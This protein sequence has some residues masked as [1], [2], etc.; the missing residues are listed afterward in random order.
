MR[1]SQARRCRGEKISL[2]VLNGARLRVHVHRSAG[3]GRPIG[4][5]ADEARPKM[6]PKSAAE[7]VLLRL[8]AGQDCFCGI[9]VFADA[10]AHNVRICREP[11]E[12]VE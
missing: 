12:G 5:T 10:K 4:G 6:T 7:T 8:L 1:L 3:V 9:A 11:W 2:L